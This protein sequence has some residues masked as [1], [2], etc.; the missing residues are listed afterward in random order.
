MNIQELFADLHGTIDPEKDLVPLHNTALAV[1][2]EAPVAYLYANPKG[3]IDRYIYFDGLYM[4]SIWLVNGN[5]T[6]TPK[7]ILDS[8]RLTIKQGSAF[9]AKLRRDKEY[10][11]LFECVDKKVLFYL[12][13]KLY[14]EIP[15]DQKWDAYHAAHIR[16]ENGFDFLKPEIWKD[17]LKNK[18]TLSKKRKS[19][20]RDL[21]AIVGNEKEITIYH[22][23][24]KGF[25]PKDEMSW[26]LDY[27]TARFFANRFNAAGEI[28][29][30]KVKVRD[31][32]DFFN[33][34]GEQEIILKS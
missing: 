33:E 3:I 6:E 26:T 17:L 34:R 28:S 11:H 12:Y 13:N 24:N 16:A 29:S 19:N 18:W 9:F 10:V 25:D 2:L 30:K 14:S 31:V 21:K 22:G 4:N 32:A 8:I 7:E 27:G 1:V 20:I 23:H 5:W 15:D